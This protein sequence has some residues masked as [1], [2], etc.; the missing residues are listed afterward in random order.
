MSVI[1]QALKDL[2]KRQ[3]QGTA[4]ARSVYQ[5]PQRRGTLLGF[6]IGVGVVGGMLLSYVMITHAMADPARNLGA[7]VPG[8]IRENSPI[9]LGEVADEGSVAEP[10]ER[11]AASSQRAADSGSV[12]ANSA[13]SEERLASNS[14]PTEGRERATNESDTIG[15]TGAE[16][17]P[18]IVVTQTEAVAS[19]LAK[20]NPQPPSQA[21]E[22]Q[23]SM[24]IERVERSADEL[25]E[26]RLRQ[27]V[28]AIEGGQGRRGETL[29]QEAL[30]LRPDYTEAR[31]RLAAYYYG[32]GFSSEAL[33][34]LQEGL[35]LSPDNTSLLALMARIYE[36]TNRPADALRMLNRLHV[37]LP[38]H[39]DLLV[40]RAALAN[41]LG[42]HRPAAEDYRALLQMNPHRGIWWLGLAYAE[43]QQGDW[44]AAKLAYQQALADKGLDRESREYV[45]SRLEAR[46]EAGMEATGEALHT[47]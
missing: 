16:A 31:Q 17:A 32:R 47:W 2:H 26:Q 28:E 14:A 10:A 44:D 33:R 22:P 6:G 39:S 4:R 15:S 29:L 23:G 35:A 34:L 40:L 20:D 7:E 9:Q 42:D 21:E 45:R 8:D 5:A 38:E 19:Q 43:E 1:N 18:Q 36:E 37:Q 24:R 11:V 3:Q 25:A 13:Q 30:T 27:G 12:A 46:L 41:E